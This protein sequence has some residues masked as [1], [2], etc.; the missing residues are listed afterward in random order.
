MI[1]EEEE[2]ELEDESSD[3]DPHLPLPDQLKQA[4]EKYH[5]AN[6]TIRSLLGQVNKYKSVI[7]EEKE[8]MQQVR[9]WN[10]H[11]VAKKK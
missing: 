2:E 10:V 9:N 8:A 11:V 6:N 3:E 4:K 7:E 1:E 5:L